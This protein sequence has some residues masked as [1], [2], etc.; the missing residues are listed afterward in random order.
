MNE[1]VEL[2]TKQKTKHSEPTDIERFVDA[3]GRKELVKQVREKI[4]AL[5]IE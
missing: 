2:E 5:G 4:D 3:P 1:R